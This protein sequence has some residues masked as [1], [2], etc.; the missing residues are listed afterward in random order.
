MLNDVGDYILTKPFENKG[1]TNNSPKPPIKLNEQVMAP[2]R[3]QPF[4]LDKNNQ[5]FSKHMYPNYN[6]RQQSLKS[7][8]SHD[9][10]LEHNHLNM[11]Q[12]MGV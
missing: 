12:Q 9:K 5:N 10:A 1:G 8:S 2:S 4:A 3:F 6:A 7:Q 11:M